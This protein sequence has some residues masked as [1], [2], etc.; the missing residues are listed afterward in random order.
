[1]LPDYIQNACDWANMQGWKVFP[2]NPNTKAPYIS[3]PFGRATSNRDAIIEL[4]SQFPGA[5]IGVPTGPS[6][7]ITVVDVDR[8]NGIDGWTEFKAL[9][10]EIPKTGVVHTPSGGFHLYF[11][12]GSLDIPNS[13][14]SIARGVDIRGSGGYAIGPGSKG[15]RGE[16]IWD[17]GYLAP[18]SPLTKIPHLLVRH[19]MGAPMSDHYCSERRSNARVE[20][21]DIITEGSR[22]ATMTSRI[23][24]LLKKLVPDVAFAAAEH[25]NDECCK[26]PLSQRELEGIFLSILKREMRNG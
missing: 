25:I 18:I 10:I 4:F 2:A 11:A 24:Y 5:A 8:K 14:S 7:R 19:C 26:P 21:M 1:M 6:N 23:G 12:S 16:Y 9:N 20:L 13:V 15:V 22:N 17:M 3:D